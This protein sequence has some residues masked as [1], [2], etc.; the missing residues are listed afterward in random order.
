MA[1]DAL[2]SALRALHHRDRTTRELDRRL[3]ERG[4]EATERE[5]AL[6]TL[7]R[8]GV[9]DDD[10]YARNRAESLASRGAGDELIRHELEAAGVD[11]DLVDGAVCGVEPEI[12]RARRI[13]ESRGHSQKTARYLRGRGYAYETIVA[14]VATGEG[15]ELR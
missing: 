9:L 15:G 6:E 14:V 11:P 1:D 10:R 12:E 5:H 13:V 2:K 8:T 4:F 7:T 3:A